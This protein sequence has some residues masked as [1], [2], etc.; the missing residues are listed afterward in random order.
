MNTPASLFR[1]A[2]VS[3]AR[4]LLFLLRALI[5]TVRRLFTRHPNATWPVILAVVI[6]TAIIKIAHA[7]TQRDRADHQ[8]ALL[9]HQIDSLKKADIKY[10]TFN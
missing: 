3:Q 9:I 8:N 6:V 2:L 4:A 5:L 7:R 10:A 1:L